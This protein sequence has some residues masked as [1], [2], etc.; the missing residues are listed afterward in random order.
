LRNAAVTDR[1][2]S[3]IFS[4]LQRFSRGA[5]D[6]GSFRSPSKADRGTFSFATLP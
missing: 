6:T 4:R 3:Q 5:R 2:Y 1:R